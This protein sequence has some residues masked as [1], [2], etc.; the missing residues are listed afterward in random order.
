M[1]AILSVTRYRGAIAITKAHGTL[2]TREKESGLG[3]REG[4]VSVKV[5]QNLACFPTGRLLVHSYKFLGICVGCTNRNNI[6]IL[7]PVIGIDTMS[8][9]YDV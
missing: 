6:V 8:A 5:K 9:V 4:K 2:R 7:V 3:N 1:L